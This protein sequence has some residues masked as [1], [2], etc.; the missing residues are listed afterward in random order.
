[1]VHA[2]EDKINVLTSELR[3][4]PRVDEENIIM[5]IERRGTER[6]ALI[7]DKLKASHEQGKILAE[8][9]ADMTKIIQIDEDKKRALEGKIRALET[10][11]TQA[12][13][14]E[15]KQRDHLLSEFSHEKEV[16]ER[17]VR[18]GQEEVRALSADM[19]RVLAEKAA[20]EVKIDS[21]K[22][23]RERAERNKTDVVDSLEFD[24][25]MLL[26]QLQSMQSTVDSERSKTADLLREIEKQKHELRAKMTNFEAQLV[27][28]K[29][30][31]GD[32]LHAVKAEK[33][34]LEDENQ[35]LKRK[36]NKEIEEFGRQS[37]S[38]KSDKD[39]LRRALEE[40]LEGVRRKASVLEQEKEKA[41]TER[42]KAERE[43]Q[44]ATED[45][46]QMK[47]DME[48]LKTQLASAETSLIKLRSQG[49]SSA[50]RDEEKN[51][52]DAHL[53]P[54]TFSP[55]QLRVLSKELASSFSADDA[56]PGPMVKVNKDTSQ[57]DYVHQYPTPY[58]HN[59]GPQNKAD[60]DK[61][62]R[63]GSKYGQGHDSRNHN[64]FQEASTSEYSTTDDFPKNRITD[65]DSARHPPERSGSKQSAPP[66][67]KQ[68]SR[69]L[70]KQK[71]LSEEVT[72]LD[73]IVKEKEEL[74]RKATEHKA[75]LK[76]GIKE[77]IT[78]FT[79]ENGRAPSV[80]DKEAVSDL[81]VAHQEVRD[82]R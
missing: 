24:K 10:R 37:E 71:S 69:Q 11:L 72:V 28:E 50:I 14:T 44:R 23:D 42:E 16:L 41:E 26:E 4:V 1:M 65:S 6:D 73:D 38:I 57:P 39:R 54:I 58:P 63:D 40:E 30:A 20:L 75:A 78:T 15:D 17:R 12:G 3:S 77:W 61:N 70:Q 22:R 18:E 56:S 19:K 60:Q 21:E 64:P 55:E 51:S 47:A 13:S 33:A 45:M 52:P 80:Q 68:K 36:L 74:V 46:K 35:Q 34:Q 5:R 7:N 9:I 67:S 66:V 2:H 76:A 59:K 25:R 8:K 48:F 82:W 43:R 27:E 31:L 29:Q 81:Y 79:E 53:G 49:S 32:K 62:R